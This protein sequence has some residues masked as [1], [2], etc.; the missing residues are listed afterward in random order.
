M[1]G[2]PEVC[3]AHAHRRQQL[4]PWAAPLLLG[5]AAPPATDAVTTCSRPI[6]LTVS[7]ALLLLTAP[8]LFVTWQ[9]YAPLSAALTSTS[10]SSGVLLVATV[11]RLLL[12]NHW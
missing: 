4:T 7:R 3:K 10:T 12:R 9:W 1:L 5:S 8:S 6:R 11:R 2:G